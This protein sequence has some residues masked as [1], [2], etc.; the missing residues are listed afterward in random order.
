MDQ[1]Q[2]ERRALVI[3]DDESTRYFIRAAFESF[4]FK[5]TEVDRAERGLEVFDQAQPDVVLVDYKMPGMDGLECC[6]RIRARWP[7]PI[8]MLSG[9]EDPLLPSL[10]V[11][12]GA[13]QF[14]VKPT[15]W[16]YLADVASKMLSRR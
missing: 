6:R 4:G 15:N 2:S 10:A 8:L 7:G 16:C 11:Q 12:A 1:A 14:F 5:V 9:R 3:D 13:D